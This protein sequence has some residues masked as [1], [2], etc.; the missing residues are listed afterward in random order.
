M[1]PAFQALLLTLILVMTGCLGPQS[2]NALRKQ[3]ATEPRDEFLDL[4]QGRVHFR[5]IRG[6]SPAILLE[7]GGGG[8]WSQWKSLQP[9]I[10]RVTGLAVVSY[11]R[12][13]FGESDLPST[14]YDALQEM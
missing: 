7:C 2:N 4:G 1:H 3:P 13:G 12:P 9:E 6:A 8:D 10:A 5:V 11:D 14:A